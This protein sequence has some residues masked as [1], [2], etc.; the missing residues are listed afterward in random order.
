VFCRDARCL[1]LTEYDTPAGQHRELLLQQIHARCA[2][3]I[4]ESTEPVVACGVSFGGLVDFRRQLATSLRQP[5]WEHFP[6][7]DWFQESLGLPCR[8]EG[9][10]NAGALG[11]FRFGAG[12]GTNSMVFVMLSTWIRCSVICHG[13][14]W[15]GK[16]GLAG[17]LGHVPVSES[18]NMCSCGAKGCLELFCSGAAIAN[19]GREFAR[20]RPEAMTPVVERSGGSVDGITARAV[21][22]AAA[23]GDAVAVHIMGEAARWLARTLITVIRIV[24]PD[25]VILGGGVALAG[26][27]LWDP[28]RDALQARTSPAIHHTT[29]IVPAELGTHSS[30]YGAAARALELS[31][32]GPAVT[33]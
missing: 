13:V 3:A 26:S 33:I 17:E 22:E 12:R 18:G 19:E 32:E 1:K 4:Q 24:N 31:C 23:A 21:A 9:D 16:D 2:A 30:L 15:R 20:R 10:A 8:I 11:E 25:K 5:G 7:A 14:L 27:V 29:E 28:L 6:L